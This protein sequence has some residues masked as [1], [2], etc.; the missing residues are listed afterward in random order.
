MSCYAQPK[1]HSSLFFLFLRLSFTLS[2]RLE[3]SAVTKSW[4]TATST[5]WFQEILLPQPPSSWYRHTPLCPG[6][7]CIFSRDRV[8]P[9]WSGWSG[10][11]D[12][13]I[14]PYGLP[15]V[16]GLQVWAS[17]PTQ[18]HSSSWSNNIALYVYLMSCLSI[19]VLMDT[20]AIVKMLIWICVYKYLFESLFLIILGISLAAELLGHLFNFFEECMSVQISPY[21]SLPILVIFH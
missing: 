11:P 15:K 19:H 6:N 21:P 8:S 17:H 1:L 5:F 14:L 4:L 9:C 20:L 7:F 13:V 2:P 3:W 18:L 12:L 10:T 16:L